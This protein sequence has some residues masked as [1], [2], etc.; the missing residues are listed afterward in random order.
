VKDP[1]VEPGAPAASAGAVRVLVVDDEAVF[2]RAVRKRLQRAGMECEVAGTLAAAEAA[3]DRGQ[4]DLVLLDMRLPDGSGLD[5]LARLRGG[6]LQRIPVMIL[7]AFG[8]LDDAVAAMKQQAV[9]Y[10]TKPIDL[11]ALLAKLEHA[12]EQG[13]IERQLAYSR[14]RETRSLEAPEMLGASAVM[15]GLRAK[16]QRVQQLA[17]RDAQAPP[18]VLILGET[19]TGKDLCARTLHLGSS[20]GDAPFVHL[21][22]AALPKDLIE[23]ELFGHQK[24]AF[25]GAHATRMGLI[26]TAENGTLFLDE[27]GELPLDVQSRL[28]AVLE[29]RMLRRI[30]ESREREVAAWFMAATNRDL[31]QMVAQGGFRADLF[32]RLDVLTI[33]VPPLAQRRED[34]LD[35]AR[36]YAARTARRYG[37]AQREFDAEACRA[38][39]DYHWPGNVRELINIVERAMLLGD[40]SRITAANLGLG[41]APVPA[42]APATAAPTG[43]GTLEAA[44]QRII[45]DALRASGGNVSRAARAL[46]VT[47]M[48]L[49]YRLQ[50]H[51]IDP[52]SF[53]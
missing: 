33:E 42:G 23:A 24:G 1:G 53:A 49:R 14:E 27:V 43:T 17:R 48:A 41:A 12:L 5:F 19:G 31:Q 32:F 4:P 15:A 21:D 10:L 37:L 40:E 44:E 26:E 52:K 3:L 18:T 22:C 8:D 38:L 28:L 50:K 39:E 9:D 20:R 35:L 11:D 25:T 2:A 51:G 29:R 47:R 6:A 16:L 7:T 36:H 13:R 46:G 45:A 34:V 30:G